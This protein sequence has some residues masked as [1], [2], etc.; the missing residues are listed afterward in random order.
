MFLPRLLFSNEVGNCF[1][2]WDSLV[3]LKTYGAPYSSLSRKS[4][5]NIRLI[6]FRFRMIFLQ[7]LLKEKRHK[8]LKLRFRML[9]YPAV[10]HGA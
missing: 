4:I 8:K 5:F 1:H 6:Q 3:T 9:E 7:A 2:A 10:K